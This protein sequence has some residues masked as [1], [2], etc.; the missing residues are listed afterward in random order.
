MDTRE[1]NTILERNVATRDTFLGVYALD[2]LP[3]NVELV[4]R[5]R[6]FLVCN[7][8]PSTRIGEHWIAIFYERGSGEVEFFDSFGLPPDA[9]DARLLAFLDSLWMIGA[10]TYNNTPLQSLD[11]DACGHYCVLFG[12]ARCRGLAFLDVIHKLAAET[13]DDIIKCIVTMIL[14]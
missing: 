5:D 3:E 13:R 10:L 11:S 9:Y 14:S 1:L 6:W 7:C 2:Q 4:R 12:V 8:C